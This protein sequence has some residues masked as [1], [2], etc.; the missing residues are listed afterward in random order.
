MRAVIDTNV[1][2]SGVFWKGP[3]REILHAWEH[4]GFQMVVSKPVLDEYERVLA[5]LAAR[6]PGVRYDRILELI[7]VHA[8]V[9][10]A[11]EF[12]KPICKDPDDDKFLGTALAANAS[13]IVSGD[14]LLLALDGFKSIRIVTP[15]SFLG[16]LG[17]IET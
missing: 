10:S 13:Y 16:K 4:Q 14:K 15:R 9:V 1:L 11:V 7:A 5:E 3:P 2:V 12:A 8:W 17:N 6:Y